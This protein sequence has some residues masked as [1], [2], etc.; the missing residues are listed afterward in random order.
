VRVFQST[1][2]TDN[3]QFTVLRYNCVKYKFYTV[4]EIM[5]VL[6]NFI[7][8]KIGSKLNTFT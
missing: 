1:I 7:K 6:T 4:T 2:L 5:I 8:R 3:S